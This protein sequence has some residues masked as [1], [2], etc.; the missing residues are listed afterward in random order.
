MPASTNSWPNTSVDLEPGS[1]MMGLDP[2]ST[3]IGQKTESGGTDLSPRQAWSLSLWEQPVPRVNLD[4]PGRWVMT[5]GLE[6]GSVGEGQES[7]F[8]GLH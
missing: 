1:V 6:P 3:G 2:G 5:A 8:M 4:E 7:G